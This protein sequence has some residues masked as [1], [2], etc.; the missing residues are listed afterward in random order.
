[1]TGDGLVAVW[2][3]PDPRYWHAYG[4]RYIEHA[5]ELAL[6]LVGSVLVL[7]AFYYHSMGSGIVKEIWSHGKAFSS[8][9]TF[10]MHMVM[11]PGICKN[12]HD[13]RFFPLYGLLDLWIAVLAVSVWATNTHF[14]ALNART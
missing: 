7:I 2:V 8:V 5:V 6:S 3:E 10:V 11:K 1:M 14:L 12:S 4:L 9:D 13:R